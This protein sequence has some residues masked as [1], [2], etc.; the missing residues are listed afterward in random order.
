MPAERLDSLALAGQAAERL[1]YT[2][3]DLAMFCEKEGNEKF[4]GCDSNRD[5]CRHLDTIIFMCVQCGW[6]KPQR[7][8]ATPNASEW[9]C[10]ECVK[11]GDYVVGARG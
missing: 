7:E 11:D 3:E 10:Q 6:W 1:N 4:E 2:T 8:N 9:A 5:F